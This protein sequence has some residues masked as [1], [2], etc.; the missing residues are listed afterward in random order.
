MV[1]EGFQG[2]TVTRARNPW[3]SAS[4]SSMG[5]SVMPAEENA[6][7]TSALR[8]PPPTALHVCAVS[9]IPRA[10]SAATHSGTE[11]KTANVTVVLG[12]VRVTVAL[13]AVTGVVGC[14]GA[15][16]YATFTREPPMSTAMR[17]RGE[18]IVGRPM[19]T[20]GLLHVKGMYLGSGGEWGR[21]KCGFSCT[22]GEWLWGMVKPHAVE[23]LPS[24]VHAWPSISTATLVDRLLNTVTVR[25][26]MQHGLDA[27]ALQ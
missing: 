24:P 17:G 14:G 11:E 21:T 23:M 16:T 25:A 18:A 13:E 9:H 20:K 8:A 4:S 15:F 5:L 7:T 26:T 2:T 10:C 19:K 27:G 3:T 22:N 12:T 6:S 1:A